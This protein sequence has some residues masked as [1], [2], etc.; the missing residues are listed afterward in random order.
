L[1][2]PRFLYRAFTK[3][4]RA[5]EFVEQGI[6][7]L[8]NI[9]QYRRAEDAT[10][11]P[12]EGSAEYLAPLPWRPEE[13]IPNRHD[14]FNSI[15]L[16][17]MSD[18]SVEWSV[19]TQFGQHIVRINDPRALYRD[20]REFFGEI[21]PVEFLKVRYTRHKR[22]DPR[23]DDWEQHRLTYSQKAKRFSPEREWRIALIAT[24]ERYPP[25]AYA[26]AVLGKRL[27]YCEIFR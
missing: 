1:R 27:D 8:G 2:V 12:D 21:A 4:K 9:Q 16:L 19:L 10:A 5:R 17:C 11:D 26:L 3:E 13:F 7:R 22:L 24:N 18:P 20:V 25:E 6:I 14:I 23:L 15:F